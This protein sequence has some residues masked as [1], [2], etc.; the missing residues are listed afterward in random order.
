MIS[1]TNT[2][3]LLLQTSEAQCENQDKISMF[4]VRPVELMEIVASV[5]QYFEWFTFG[6]KAMNA[7]DITNGLNEDVRRCMWIDG[8]GR[9][10]WLRK[11][12]RKDFRRH[13]DSLNYEDMK[14]HSVILRYALMEMID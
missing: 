1:F 5:K 11:S 8:I 4:G 10:V 13:L 3:K 2:Q 9:R 7:Q 6:V 12:A 14:S